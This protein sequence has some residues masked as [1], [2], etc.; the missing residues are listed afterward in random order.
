MNSNEELSAIGVASPAPAN[1]HHAVPVWY[2][3]IIMMTI[4]NHLRK[5]SCNHSQLNGS[6]RPCCS[7]WMTVTM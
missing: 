7:C 6:V 3:I 4:V 1:P 2:I 5:I